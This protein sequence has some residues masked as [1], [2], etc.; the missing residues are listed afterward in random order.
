MIKRKFL[1]EARGNQAGDVSR[2]KEEEATHVA[3]SENSWNRK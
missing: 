1:K 2:S 3:S